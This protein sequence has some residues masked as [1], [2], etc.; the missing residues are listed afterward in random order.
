MPKLELDSVPE[1]RNSNY[2]KPFDEQV[3]AFVRQ[4]LGDAGGLA[5][6]G[7]NRLVLPPGSWS[8][9]RHWH[10]HDDEFIFVISG[11]LVLITESGEQVMRAGDCAAFP[12]NTPNGHHMINR[13]NSVA[14]CLE[15]GS[16]N[17][18]DAVMY[19]DIDL[20]FDP[21]L[22]RYARKDGAYPAK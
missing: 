7:V 15:V 8:G 22:G 5:Q 20:V 11:E 21:V 16:R 3:G 10:S 14:V 13:S 19:P 6:F 9:Q 17:E 12:A 18:N 4:R 1:R 2:P